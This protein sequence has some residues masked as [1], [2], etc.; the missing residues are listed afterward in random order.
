MGLSVEKAEVNEEPPKRR[1]GRPRKTE[2][3][4]KTSKKPGRPKKNDAKVTTKRSWKKKPFYDPIHERSEK[5]ESFKPNAENLKTYQKKKKQ[6]SNFSEKL[7]IAFN[8]I[9]MNNM[10]IPDIEAHSSKIDCEQPE[11]PNGDIF[12]DLPFEKFEDI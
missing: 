7:S 12:K 9:E 1:R 3:V 8:T 2:H 11:L 5:M 10:E 6:K 4:K